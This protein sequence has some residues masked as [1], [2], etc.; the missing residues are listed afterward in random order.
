L[1]G[2][3]HGDTVDANTASGSITLPPNIVCT[4]QADLIRFLYGTTPH[5]STP[6]PQYFY[7][8]V[9]L[10]PLNDD[11]RKLNLHILHLFPGTVCTYISADTQV[12][13]VGMQHFPNMVPVEFLNSLNA[14]GLPLAK[15]KLKP[16]SPI[17]LLQ[18][19]DHKLGLCNGTRATVVRMSNRVL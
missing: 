12:I 3:G 11:V 13:E 1:L 2:L 10:A 4:D 19:L 18:N 7:D 16:G 6:L 17:I 9:L 8:R 14:S 5:E 15:L